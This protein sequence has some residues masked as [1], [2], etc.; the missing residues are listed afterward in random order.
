MMAGGKFRTSSKAKAD[1]SAWSTGEIMVG[2]IAK[3]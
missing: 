3:V 2:I 1:I